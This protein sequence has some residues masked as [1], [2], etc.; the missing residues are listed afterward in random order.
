MG[1]EEKPTVEEEHRQK[2]A[3]ALKDPATRG[4]VELG[5]LGHPGVRLLEDHDKA[6]RMA[7]EALTGLMK[8]RMTFY[9][10]KI[11]GPDKE[12]HLENMLEAEEY[13]TAA[14]KKLFGEDFEPVE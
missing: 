3:E 9:I 4:L 2:V 5:V 12:R 10:V 11:G 6:K 8:A 13:F 7:R 1:E 14:Y